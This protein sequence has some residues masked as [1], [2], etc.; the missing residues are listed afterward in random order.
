MPGANCS[1]YGCPISRGNKGVT[2][3]KVPVPNS[4]FNKEW[5][6]EL[7]NVITKDR[8]IDDGLKRR[9]ACTQFSIC[10]RHFTEDQFWTCEY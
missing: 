9:I 6:N 5:R 3:F 8:V 2:I 7:I 4:D 1:I 10:E